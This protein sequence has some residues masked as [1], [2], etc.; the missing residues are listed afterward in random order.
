MHISLNHWKAS[1]TRLLFIDGAAK[2]SAA[3]IKDD[4][5]DLKQPNVKTDLEKRLF[6]T[7]SVFFLRNLTFYAITNQL[8]WL[9]FVF[10]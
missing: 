3:Y 10:H 8:S 2:F 4:S 1:E 7:G 6:V 5:N 9:K